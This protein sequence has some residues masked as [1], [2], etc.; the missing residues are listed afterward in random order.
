MGKL[1]SGLVAAM[2]WASVS[3]SALATEVGQFYGA[4]D[5]G[6]GTQKSFCTLAQPLPGESCDNAGIGFRGAVGYQVMPNLAVEG[7]YA[8]YGTAKYNDNAGFTMDGNVTG[9]Q[10][11]AIGSYPVI[12]A[13]SLTGKLGLALTNG[14]LAIND[15]AVGSIDFDDDTTTLVWGIGVRYDVNT[16]ISVRAQYESLGKISYDNGIFAAAAA[17]A[18]VPSKSNVNILTAGV[19]YNF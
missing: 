15:V 6:Q 18:G 16:S 11:S 7:S 19:I 8:N 2:L 1:K 12:N 3:G 4:I 10:F 13:F 14:E 17:A 9:F 5:V